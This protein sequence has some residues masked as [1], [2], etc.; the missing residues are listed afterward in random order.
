M[1]YFFL[2]FLLTSLNINAQD[3]STINIHLL[4]EPSKDLKFNYKYEID[5]EGENTIGKTVFE[6]NIKISRLATNK[7]TSLF[8]IEADSTTFSNTNAIEDGEVAL[9][10]AMIGLNMKFKCDSNG[11]LVEVINKEEVISEFKN[12]IRGMSNDRKETLIQSMLDEN[13]SMLFQKMYE[14]NYALLFQFLNMESTVPFESTKDSLI[15]KTLVQPKSTIQIVQENLKEGD[16][17]IFRK[18]ITQNSEEFSQD[19]TG[20]EII[21][22]P[23]STNTVQLLTTDDM[24]LIKSLSAKTV[25]KMEGMIMMSNGKIMN[26]MKPITQYHNVGY[27]KIN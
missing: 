10:Y 9:I 2:I 12:G 26:E 8:Y 3:L 24:G 14:I 17:N 19:G 13:E 4:S 6:N 15:E 20:Y 7:D 1:K 5:A 18:T 16:E 25:S 22:K 23:V 27:I 21:N 11:K